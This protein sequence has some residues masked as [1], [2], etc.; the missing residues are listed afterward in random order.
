MTAKKPDDADAI[1]ALMEAGYMI[2]PL[3]R[4]DEREGLAFDSNLSRL[5]HMRMIRL[6]APKGS[7]LY[8]MLEKDEKSDKPKIYPKKRA[9]ARDTA[10]RGK[11]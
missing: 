2:M 5:T 10:R 8:K 6:A 1:V 11:P 4:S 9:A 3:A 7:A